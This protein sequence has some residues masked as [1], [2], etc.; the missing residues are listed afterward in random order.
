[1]TVAHIALMIV[2]LVMLLEGGWGVMAPLQLR[3]RVQRLMEETLIEPALQ[4]NTYWAAALFF[5]L[6]AIFGQTWAHRALF[7]LGVLAMLAGFACL[8]VDFLRIWYEW[9]LAKRSAWTIRF[10]YG[11]E[12]LLAFALIGLGLSGR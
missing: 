2:A 5:W 6:L 9:A 1:M 11:L 4:R 7:G 8:R 3:D 12:C 10:L